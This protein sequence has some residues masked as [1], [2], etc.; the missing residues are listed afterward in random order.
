MMIDNIKQLLLGGTLFLLLAGCQRDHFLDKQPFDKVTNEAFWTSRKDA[1]LAL[2]GCYSSLRTPA[3]AIDQSSFSSLQFEG[4]T[5]N[6]YCNSTLDNY[7]DISR[8]VITPTTGGIVTRVWTD[9]YKGIARCNWFLGNLHRVPD[10]TEA[11]KAR[12]KGEAYFLRAFMYNELTMLYG[13]VPLITELLGFG[14]DVFKTKKAPRMDIVKKMIRDL[15]SAANGL[16]NVSYADG[17]PVRASAL[18]LKARMCL[19]NGL[20]QEAADAAKKV[21][22]EGKAALAKS[23]QGIFWGEQEGNPEILFSVKASSPT[24]IH[25]LDLLYGSRF[26]MVPLHT[27]VDC[28]EMKDGTAP[29]APIVPSFYDPKNRMRNDFYQNRDPRLKLTI[30]TPG[31]PWAYNPT[32]GFNNEAK[33]KAE[34][35]SVNNLGIRKYIN[36]TVNDGS[37][38]PAG[39]SQAIV[40]LRYADVL[41]MYAEAMVELGGGST[42]DP[43]ALKAINDVRARP[44]VAMPAKTAPLTRAAIRNERRV[45]LAFEGLRYYDIK[46]WKIAKD[47][48]NGYKD[49][50][51][52]T[53]VFEDRFYYWPVPQTEVDMM[54]IDFQNPDYR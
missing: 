45:E 31:D 39:S 18:A 20:W 6:A 41:L 17:H 40:K 14:P 53:R 44:G 16:L 28:Y 29:V 1:E 47:V 32:I 35:P 7:T 37:G 42:S 50:G 23:Y 15:D 46:R 33:F 19:Y 12:M 36:L 38:G 2:T 8:G 34:S 26:S 11:D 22:D 13:D 48:L 54:G 27:L 9:A 4:L 43:L 5:D 49:P 24:A 30:F 25:N 3:F 52:V 21:M 51:N 10:L